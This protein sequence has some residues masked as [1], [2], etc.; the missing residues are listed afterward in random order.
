MQTEIVHIDGSHGEG[1]GQILRSSLSL[2]MVTG[3][4]VRISSI[5]A[6]RPKPGLL[7]QHL[8]AVQAAQRISRGRVEGALLGSTELTFYPQT[9]THGSYEFS[10]GTAGSTTLVLQTL[11]PALMRVPGESIL[12]IE[13]GTHNP[14][15]PPFEFLSRC[16]APCI[17]KMGPR[18][19]FQ[20]LRPGFH[21]AGGGRIRA[22]IQSRRSL[23]PLQLF[24]R[25]TLR[26]IEA[27]ALV[28]HLSPTIA[29][30]ELGVLTNRLKLSGSQAVIQQL[31]TSIG[32]GN[33]VVVSI[34]SEA[35]TEVVSAVGTRGLS[36]E[37]VARRAAD[38]VEAYLL[39]DAPV[40]EFLADQLLL[41][42]ALAGSGGF[43]TGR[44]SQHALTN[45]DVIRRFVDTPIQTK[46]SGRQTRVVFGPV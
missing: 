6:G 5:R 35:V 11:L 18:L 21:P 39:A 10:I 37:K 2:A 44:L 12:D 43:T 4:P 8:T 1:G 9:P 38:A 30:R 29:E 41:P 22:R 16:F 46:Q 36:A 23:E 26:S 15:A 42:C 17:E 32:P 34:E 27:K 40:G 19:S 7:R 20:L 31:D 28:A 45:I 25:G 33:S 3:K 24:E 14:W 13:G